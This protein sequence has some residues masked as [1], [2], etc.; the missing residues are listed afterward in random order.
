MQIRKCC[1]LFAVFSAC[2]LLTSC[3]RAPEKR[4]ELKGKVV[5]VDKAHRQVT[6]EHEQIP[7]FMDAMTMA[8]N[9]RE[10]W[11][12]EALAPGQAIEATLVLQGDQSWIEGI[13][14]SQSAAGG[15]PETAIAMPGIGEE[16]PDFKL[17]NQ[18][19]RQI[20]LAQYRGRPLLLTFIYTRCPLP[21]YCPRTSRNFSEIY[22][23][24]KSVAKADQKPHLLTVSFDTEYDTP[25]VLR[26]Y[27]RRYMNPPDFG[28]WE[29]ATGSPEDI[30]NITGHFGLI[31]R[32]ES[33]QIT[34]SLVTALIGADGKLKQI[35]QGNEW[36]PSQVLNAFRTLAP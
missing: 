24:L 27:A 8:F 31:Y 34:H 15:R 2:F 25:A 3:R 29:F 21:D 13:R 4:F 7:G 19:N 18:D 23:G 16:V 6:I 9:V 22:R 1:V 35:F 20:H 26:E 12:L 30:K 14:I 28:A 10:D 5:S 11:A 32:K 36:T 33:G 17:I